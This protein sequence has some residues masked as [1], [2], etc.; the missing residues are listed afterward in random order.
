M[1]KKRDNS[2][3]QRVIEV[4]PVASTSIEEMVKQTSETIRLNFMAQRSLRKSKPMPNKIKAEMN[5]VLNLMSAKIAESGT[6]PARAIATAATVTAAKSLVSAATEATATTA[7]DAEAEVEAT[8]PPQAPPPAIKII[9]EDATTSPSTKA[10]FES[11]EDEPS[12]G[13]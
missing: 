4:E 13:N 1:T 3:E 9:A 12:T 7:A 2:P 11:I 5:W 6:K 10:S 8:S